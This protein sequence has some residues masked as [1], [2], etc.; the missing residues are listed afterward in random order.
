MS[1]LA[2]QKS[3]STVGSGVDGVRIAFLPHL[4]GRDPQAVRIGQAAPGPEVELIVVPGAAQH[5][6]A[7][8]VVDLADRTARDRSACQAAL[9][10][11][12]LLMRAAVEY[13]EHLAVGVDDDELAPARG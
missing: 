13:G 9:G 6:R 5:A 1:G 11:Q 7:R 8:V 10:E 4:V 12:R 3:T 2:S